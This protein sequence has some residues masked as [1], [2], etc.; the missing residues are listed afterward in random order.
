MA[1]EYTVPGPVQVYIGTGVSPAATIS[2][3]TSL[4]A[5]GFASDD[6][7]IRVEIEYL[8]NPV[9][10]SDTGDENSEYVYAGMTVQISGTLSKW[11]PVV[12]TEFVQ[13][14]G[15]TVAANA[16]FGAGVIGTTLLVPGSSSSALSLALVPLAAGKEAWFFP[17]CYVDG[18]FAL[19]DMGNTNMKAGFSATAFRVGTLAGEV[20]DLPSGS[21]A[22]QFVFKKLTTV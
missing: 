8:N 9:S 14:T 13:G 16:G 15:S 7:L 12:A 22:T 2:T 3:L 4:D 17:R 10:A 11:D 5:L 20:D 18:P 1:Q 6:D 19:S 21:T